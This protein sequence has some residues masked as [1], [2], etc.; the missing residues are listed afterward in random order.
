MP[1]VE[2]FVVP[3]RGSIVNEDSRDD[4]G[5]DR[6][7]GCD[8]LAK[9]YPAADAVVEPPAVCAA[10][11]ESRAATPTADP[12]CREAL[13]RALARPCSSS[14]TPAVPTTTAPNTVLVVANPR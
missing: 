8:A 7:P 10:A 9:R 11:M 6:E 13:T 14:V 4:R 3:S 2:P 5:D 1:S 12:T